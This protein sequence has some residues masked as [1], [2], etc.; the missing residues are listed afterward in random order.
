MFLLRTPADAIRLSSF[1][2]D[3]NPLVRMAARRW[4]IQSDTVAELQDAVRTSVTAVLNAD[5]PRGIA[6]AAIV[7]GN[8][9]HEPA[10]ERLVALLAHEAGDV[11]IGAAR[12]LRKLAVPS[13]AE[14]IFR[15]LRQET[16][17]SLIEIPM[18]SNP[19]LSWVW[20]MYEQHKHLL[21]LLGILDYRDANAYL[22]QYLPFPPTPPVGHPFFWIHCTHRI[23]PGRMPHMGSRVADER[24]LRLNY[25]WILTLPQP[26]QPTD[27]A[28]D[29]VTDAGDL[30]E[31]RDRQTRLLEQLADAAEFSPDAA[32]ALLS[33]P[34]G[35]L[36]L[37]N[38]VSLN[39]FSPTTRQTLIDHAVASV[40]PHVRE[41]FE[42]CIP[43]QQRRQ[44]PELDMARIVAIEGD[45]VA[46]EKLFFA[47]T[48]LKCR[49]CHRIGDRGTQ[50]AEQID[51]AGRRTAGT[52]Y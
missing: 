50:L 42:Q 13:T 52:R 4:L 35:A 29:A 20:D 25:D 49:S 38:A 11:S 43:E 32:A 21:E 1:L 40:S 48:R 45:P 36:M 15:H 5:G 6:Q 46:G 3:P 33:E 14:P 51:H 8:L 22:R 10:A 17:N 37:L 44:P 34:E 47:D 30:P 19:D 9:D 31:I 18:N 16:D 41:V 24:G 26:S 2:N 39:R 27:A 23:G 7:V 28:T 12:A